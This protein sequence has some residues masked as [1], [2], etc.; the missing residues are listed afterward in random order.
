MKELTKVTTEVLTGYAVSSLSKKPLS[1]NFTKVERML[2]LNKC[3][4]SLLIYI[5]LFNES[6]IFRKLFT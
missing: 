4:S 3:G 6:E 1:S 5:L 2:N